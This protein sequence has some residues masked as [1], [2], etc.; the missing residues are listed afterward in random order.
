MTKKLTRIESQRSLRSEVMRAL[1]GCAPTLKVSSSPSF[2][3]RRSA[4]PS[5]TD[6]SC[7]EGH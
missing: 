1:K 7:A 4:I 2:H 5:S 3:P 6:S